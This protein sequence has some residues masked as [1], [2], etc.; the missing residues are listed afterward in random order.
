MH[1]SETQLVLDHI[2]QDSMQFHQPLFVVQL[3]HQMEHQ[4]SLGG[5]ITDALQE[6]Q[7]LCMHPQVEQAHCD[8]VVYGVVSCRDFQ[9]FVFIQSLS[10]VSQMEMT[11]SSPFFVLGFRE[12]GSKGV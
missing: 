3:V 12:L 10:I 2:R 6:I 9:S 11:E 7:A 5:T 4:S 1:T 8:V